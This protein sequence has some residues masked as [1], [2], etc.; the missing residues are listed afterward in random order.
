MYAIEFETFI[1]DNLVKLPRA[2]VEL[3][4]GK[5]KVIVLKEEPVEET[6]TLIDEL[7]A[8]PLELPNF[9]PFSREEIYAAR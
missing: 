2:Y 4:A 7:L 9:I 6:S 3:L 8:H 5:V 1:E